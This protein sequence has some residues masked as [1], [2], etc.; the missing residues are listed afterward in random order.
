[1]DKGT[2]Y[3][4]GILSLILNT[5]SPGSAYPAE[6]LRAFSYFHRSRAAELL[7]LLDKNFPNAA[8]RPD[9]HG[10][11][12]EFYSSNGQSEAVLK[13]GKE[14][15]VSFPKSGDRTPVPLLIAD[16]DPRLEKPHA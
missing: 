16:T 15:L 10:K 4:N 8:G 3:M 13:G 6:E 1:M 14:F 11:L 9:L 5:T 2:G 12:F 7:A